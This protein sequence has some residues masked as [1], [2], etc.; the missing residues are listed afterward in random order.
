MPLNVLLG[1]KPLT[2]P[3]G[4]EF[5]HSSEVF[6]HILP[7]KL[8]LFGDVFLLKDFLILQ[9]FLLVEHIVLHRTTSPLFKATMTGLMFLSGHRLVACVLLLFSDGHIL[10]HYTVRLIPKKGGNATS[11]EGPTHLRVSS[12]S[13]SYRR[14]L[15]SRWTR[16]SVS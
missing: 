3:L 2:V 4:D 5:P 11:G 14:R 10:Y 13:I 6:G 7:R 15:I 8:V 1:Y 16:L 12:N 9:N